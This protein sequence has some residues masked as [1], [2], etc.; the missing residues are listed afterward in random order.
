MSIQSRARCW[1]N[2]GRFY[3]NRVAAYSELFSI[4][5]EQARMRLVRE[6]IALVALAVAALFSLSFLSIAVIATALRT[7]RFVYI[8]WAVA[9]VWMLLCAASYAVVRGQRPARPF[10]V[11]REEIRNDLKT[12]RE[13]LR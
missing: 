3:A 8:A 5:L 12:V 9:V 6:V 11:V 13:A 2:V 1:R 4:E 10:K 7:S